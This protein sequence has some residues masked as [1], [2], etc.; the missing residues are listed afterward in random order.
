MSSPPRSA[1]S[2]A[3]RFIEHVDDNAGPPKTFD[4]MNLELGQVRTGSPP[5]R[6]MSLKRVSSAVRNLVRRPSK[7]EGK[8][9]KAKAKTLTK[10]GGAIDDYRAQ[11]RS[12]MSIERLREQALNGHILDDE[13]LRRLAEADGVYLNPRGAIQ[14]YDDDHN[15]SSGLVARLSG[16]LPTGEYVFLG[17]NSYLYV[18][19][20]IFGK[21]AKFLS[22][23]AESE[24]RE[25]RVLARAYYQLCQSRLSPAART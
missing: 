22:T 6:K 8:E 7:K 21:G 25:Y 9:E 11:E 13:S 24:Y 1:G 15:L 16:R 23:K 19:R 5:R 17:N 2:G 12:S 18:G 14:F 10:I 3:S 20:H 4:D